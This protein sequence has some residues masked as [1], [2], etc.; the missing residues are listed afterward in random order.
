MAS[1]LAFNAVH[2]E[3]VAAPKIVKLNIAQKKDLSKFLSIVATSSIPNFQNGKI[4]NDA[5]INFGL[6]ASYLENQ[7]LFQVLNNQAPLARIKDVHVQSRAVHYFGKYVNHQSISVLETWKYSN[8]YY[9]G[10]IDAYEG[11]YPRDIQKLQLTTD[12]K[13]FY[14]ASF[15]AR[16]TSAFG[17]GEAPAKAVATLKKVE[18][19]GKSRFILF[20]YQKVN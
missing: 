20:G 6:E 12:G 5:L 2:Q 4:A 19:K 18:S 10:G 15:Q 17:E 8:T 11:F 1:L 14:T 7:D 3:A 13:G 16:D 9:V